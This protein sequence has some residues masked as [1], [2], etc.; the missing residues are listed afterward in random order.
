MSVESTIQFM[1]NEPMKNRRVQ[2]A[3]RYAMA[4]M[5]ATSAS[6]AFAQEQ[7]ASSEGVDTVIVTGSRLQK[8]VNDASISP[9]TSVTASDVEA[10]GLTRLEDVLNNMPQIFAA[11][12]STVSN[13][14]DGTATINLRNLGASRSLVLVNGRRLGP[15]TAAGNNR[16]DLNQI[17]ASLIERID[18]LTGGA[19]AVYGADAVAGVVNFVLNT[20]FEGIK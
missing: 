3:V 13:G 4:A 20:K 17:P 7:A 14:S 12:G 6:A 1:R 2:K 18:I 9:I 16:S 11:Q 15:G 5:A 10:T 19:S 8:N